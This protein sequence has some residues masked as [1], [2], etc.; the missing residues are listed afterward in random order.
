VTY[1]LVVDP[2]DVI[3]LVDADLVALAVSDWL[4]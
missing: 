2:V 4:D 3:V 1:V